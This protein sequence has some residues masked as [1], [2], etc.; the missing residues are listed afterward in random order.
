MGRTT[1]SSSKCKDMFQTRTGEAGV[2]REI[3]PMYTTSYRQAAPL[4]LGRVDCGGVRILRSPERHTHTPVQVPVQ[5][6]VYIFSSVFLDSQSNMAKSNG[7]S[8]GSL[9]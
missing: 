6:L 7:P 9:G 4:P 2:L 8:R 3:T 5:A 1:S